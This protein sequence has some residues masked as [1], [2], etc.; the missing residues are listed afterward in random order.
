M[1]HFH[2]KPQ[3]VC[4]FVIRYGQRIDVIKFFYGG[5][6]SPGLN[7]AVAIPFRMMM[8]GCEIC[9]VEFSV[10]SVNKEVAQTSQRNIRQPQP[11]MREFVGGTI[12]WALALRQV[13]PQKLHTSE[14]APLANWIYKIHR[15]IRRK[16]DLIRPD[17]LQIWGI[18][19]IVW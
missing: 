8:L 4:K 11:H 19:I 9:R 3:F 7:L 15:E 13:W 1:S 16:N 17:L 5:G 6:L 18:K 2:V 10:D 14:A 12:L